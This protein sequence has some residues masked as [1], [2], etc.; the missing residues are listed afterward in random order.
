MKSTLGFSR[1]GTVSRGTGTSASTNG[2]RNGVVATLVGLSLFHSVPLFES[3]VRPSAVGG[4]EC[5]VWCRCGSLRQGVHSLPPHWHCSL[6]LRRVCSEVCHDTETT[7]G[8][9]STQPLDQ[10]LGRDDPDPDP[11][12]LS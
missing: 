10:G 6:L 1:C 3:R 7:W 9:P 11:G 4:V 8:V 12:S 5:R 2:S